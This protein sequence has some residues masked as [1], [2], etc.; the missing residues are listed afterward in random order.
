MSQGL[1]PGQLGWRGS[2]GASLIVRRRV[3]FHDLRPRRLD[4]G[5]R[6]VEVAVDEL[7]C[8]ALPHQPH[9]GLEADRAEQAVVEGIEGERREDHVLRQRLEARR[10][11]CFPPGQDDGTGQSAFVPALDGVALWRQM[12]DSAFAGFRELGAEHRLRREA[13]NDVDRLVL[14]RDRLEHGAEGAGVGVEGAELVGEQA[15]AAL[16]KRRRQRALA[17]ARHRRQHKGQT[18]ALNRSSMQQQ[19]VVESAADQPIA[20]PF[21]QRQRAVAPETAR[22]VADRHTET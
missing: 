7:P 12:G 22:T 20:A 9:R 14:Q 3:T 18:A 10:A 4:G 17:R 21:E 16:R 1:Q 2:H 6:I 19:K 8:R 13:A 11:A 5:Q 15:P